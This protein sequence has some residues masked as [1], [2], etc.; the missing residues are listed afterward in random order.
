MVQEAA[1]LS[2]DALA[3]M[4]DQAAKM[5]ACGSRW[6]RMSLAA[7]TAPA[8][9]AHQRFQ[10][11]RCG[12]RGCPTC[13]PRARRRQGERLRPGAAHHPAGVWWKTTILLTVARSNIDIEP[14]EAWRRIG[15]WTTRFL[16]ALRRR[17]LRRWPGID[18]TDPR[19][20]YAW[21][22][23]AHPKA[24]EWPHVH[25]VLSMPYPILN[26]DGE[27]YEWSRRLWAKIT[28][29][30]I[31]PRVSWKRIWSA[32]GM[33]NYLVPYLTKCKMHPEHW[34]ILYRRR[35]MA[36]TLPATPK[37]EPEG[38]RIEEWMSGEMARRVRE[39]LDARKG[40]A[41]IG[42]PV[43]AWIALVQVVEVRKVTWE[44][45]ARAVTP[46]VHIESS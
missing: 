10:A 2:E 27:W 21:V 7:D 6:A 28:G 3:R 36:S 46:G 8:G 14:E 22:I 17:N 24:P 18:K 31:L 44:D 35:L 39:G 9:L 38:W 43:D 42:E 20:H 34:A 32:P 45:V 23:E 5:A 19:M 15:K 13:G 40:E 16:A 29:A 25:V 33:A 11:I 41:V 30:N 4:A 37:P 12:Q 26:N 1:R